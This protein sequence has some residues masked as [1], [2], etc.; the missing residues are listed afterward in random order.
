MSHIMPIF[1]LWN[2]YKIIVLQW[3]NL[4]KQHEIIEDV[5][6][7]EG[8]KEQEVKARREEQAR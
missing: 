4:A 3:N 2:K 7:V 8:R 5:K 6:C 1:S